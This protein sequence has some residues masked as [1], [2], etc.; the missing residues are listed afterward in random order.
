MT[1]AV[2]PPELLALV[3]GRPVPRLREELSRWGCETESLLEVDRSRREAILGERFIL[4]LAPRGI[5]DDALRL[6]AARF[7]ADPERGIVRAP[8]IGQAPG[9]RV[10]LGERVVLS[11]PASV[12][13]GVRG[14]VA[15]E[16][17][18]VGGIDLEV[19]IAV[20]DRAGEHLDS[21]NEESSAWASWAADLGAMPSWADLAL[22][23]LRDTF[24]GSLG[25]EGDRRRAFTV[26]LLEAFVWAATSTKLWEVRH[27]DRE[28]PS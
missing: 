23:P 24:R 9:L 25:A 4:W 13:I 16:R 15:R 12:S 21:V 6:A 26:S 1:E 5:V 20:P 28:G 8:H 17:V 7:V 19:G 14:P 3:A 10:P 18:A 2:A 27:P 22:G 11:A